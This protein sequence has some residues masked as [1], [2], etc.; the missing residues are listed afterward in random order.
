M[1]WKAVEVLAL[2]VALIGILSMNISVVGISGISIWERFG[3]VVISAATLAG[4]YYLVRSAVFRLRVRDKKDRMRYTRPQ[5]FRPRGRNEIIVQ[6]LENLE[7]KLGELS[8]TNAK[9]VHTLDVPRLDY[10][11]FEIVERDPDGNDR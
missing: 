10:D 2:F 3:I 4:F 6:R 11:S 7:N 5:R 1:T 8:S 9:L